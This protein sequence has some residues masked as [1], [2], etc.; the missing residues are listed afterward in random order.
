[1]NKLAFWLLLIISPTASIFQIA[2]VATLSPWFAP[3]YAFFVVLNFF[4]FMIAFEYLKGIDFYRY[5][6][7][8]LTL[9]AWRHTRENESEEP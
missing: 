5:S 1:M 2:S 7:P 6:N 8:K 4:N 3:M 9:I